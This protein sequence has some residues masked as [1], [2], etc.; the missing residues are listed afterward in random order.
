MAQQYTLHRVYWGHIIPAPWG[1]GALA[2]R[3]Q[4]DILDEITRVLM[5]E[6]CLLDTIKYKINSF[7]EMS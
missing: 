1:S 6:K 2:Q 3:F 7:D 4:A 5:T